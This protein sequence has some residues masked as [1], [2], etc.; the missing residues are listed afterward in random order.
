M[1][2]GMCI[3]AMNMFFYQSIARI[4]LGAAVAIEFVGPLGVAALGSR[5]PIHF[6]WVGLAAF[7][8]LLLS[9]LTGVEL[10]ELGILFALMAG[11]GWGMFIPLS[12]KVSNRVPENDGLAIGMSVAAISMLP[13]AIPVIPLATGDP[14][15]LLALVSLALLSTTI[16]F[17]LEFE[18][19]KK[20]TARNYGILVSA[21]P[22]VAALLG[23][24]LLGERI[25]VPGIVAVACVVIAA[26]G[27]T[28]GDSREAADLHNSG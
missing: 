6:L 5:K 13:F 12:R 3:A 8:I 1:G 25:G 17:T 27:I 10:D 28:L 26:I 11:L 9:P 14:L 19:L 16:P 2:Y 15:I 21:E 22:A 24:I 23:A 7:G 4:P 18:A 20:I